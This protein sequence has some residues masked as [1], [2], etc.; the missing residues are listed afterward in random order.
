[1][2]LQK[3]GKYGDGIKRMSTCEGSYMPGTVCLR[4][5]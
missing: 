4:S 5:V 2:R 3:V 1:M